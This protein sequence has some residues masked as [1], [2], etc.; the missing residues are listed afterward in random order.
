MASEAER[1][2]WFDSVQGTDLAQGDILE[3]LRCFSFDAA[4]S[5]G[6]S[7]ATLSWVVRDAIVMTQSCDLVAEQKTISEVLL[8]AVWKRPEIPEFQRDD[9]MESIRC[10]RQYRYHMLAESRLPGLERSIR[11]VDFSR[12]TVYPLDVLRARAAASGPRLRLLPPYR[13]HMSQAFARF[14][15][16]VGLPADIPRFRKT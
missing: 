4:T 10:G 7:E 11:V 12:V 15:M 13:E 2:P 3:G 8:C 14:F 9:V 1:Y 6:A 16:R 5:A